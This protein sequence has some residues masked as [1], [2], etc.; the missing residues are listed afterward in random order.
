MCLL[1]INN[2]T[3]PLNPLHTDHILCGL[4]KVSSWLITKS[5]R[6]PRTS[7]IWRAS[8]SR[9]VS[10]R[11]VVG[12]SKN[13]T[14]MLLISRNN[15]SLTRA[16]R[17]SVRRRKAVK[18]V[19]GDLL[20]LVQCH[21]PRSMQLAAVILPSIAKDLGCATADLPNQ[22]P[23]NMRTCLTQGTAHTF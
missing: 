20:P 9:R 23:C 7:R 19:V 22:G 5:C 21:S 18:I 14:S 2:F 1:V 11:F 16:L 15:A 12:S 10:S 6:K 13:A 3:A 8:D 4:L 17:S